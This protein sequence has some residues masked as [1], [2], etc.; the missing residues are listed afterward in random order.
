MLF[1]SNRSSAPRSD[2][3]SALLARASRS[4]RSL[5]KSIRCSQST[6]IV[7]P[8]DAMFVT[9]SPVPRCWPH[10]ARF[11][12]PAEERDEVLVT[13]SALDGVLEQVAELLGEGQ[14]DALLG[15]KVEHEPDVLQHQVGRERGGVV[16]VEQRLRLVLHEARADHRRADRLEQLVPVDSAQLAQHERLAEEL[17]RSADQDLEDELGDARGLFLTDIKD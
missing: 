17:G 15:G 12:Q 4:E 8:R 1:G 3:A 10:D 5:A 9:G 16:P 2:S 13:V 14:L 11:L 7:A 6:A